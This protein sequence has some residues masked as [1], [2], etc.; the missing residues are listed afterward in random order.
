MILDALDREARRRQP[1]IGDPMRREDA[2]ERE[3]VDGDDA[4]R[5]AVVGERSVRR[6]KSG[7]PVVRMNELRA[8]G[9]GALPRSEQ[10]RYVRQQAE[11]QRVV[12]PVG[13]AG[14]LV[15]AA[16][17]VVEERTIDHPDRNAGGQLGLEQARRGNLCDGID[18]SNV[19]RAYQRREHRG[20][21]GQ[22][23]ARVEPDLP[24][25]DGKRGRDVAQTAGLDERRAF[26]RYVEDAKRRQGQRRTVRS[27]AARKR[28][29][30]SVG[31]G[32]VPI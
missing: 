27:L 1:Q 22:E 28:Q 23:Q 6:R 29:L 8:P 9:D 31:A 7:L 20:V 18:R 21:P 30:N 10:S 24:Q 4:R 32:S 5:R 26:R 15:R 25:R 11:A 2:L 17:A 14:V 16:V 12:L 19:A 13:A 3:V